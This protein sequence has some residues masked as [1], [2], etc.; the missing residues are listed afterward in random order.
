MIHVLVVD[1]EAPA[2]DELIFLLE[3]VPGVVID[4]TADNGQEALR[5]ILKL[6]PQV[7]FLDIQ[8]PDMTGLAVCRELLTMLKPSELPIIIFATAY[9]QHALEAFQVNAVDYILKPFDEERLQMTMEKIR[10]LLSRPAADS[11]NRILALLEKPRDAK[12][13]VELNERILLLNPQEI[14]FCSITARHVMI[15]TCSE[16]YKTN[17]NLC[18]LEDKLGFLRTHKS[19]LVNPDKVREVI[20]WF[21]GTY[22]LLM[23]DDKASSVPVSRTYLKEVRQRLNF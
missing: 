18:E 19:Y 1:D 23:A 4:D 9:D 15:M 2:R 11:L 5:K 21:N 14:I 22:N 12:I 6:R 17:Y 7:V 3:R 16:E 13:P 10:R 8:M 20:P